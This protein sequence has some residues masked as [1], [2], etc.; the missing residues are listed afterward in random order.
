MVV[1]ALGALFPT[2]FPQEETEPT[3]GVP[4]IRVEVTLAVLH[5]TVED[6]SG[7]AI[8]GLSKENFMVYD[9]GVPQEISVFSDED[10]PVTMGLVI[11]NSGSMANKRE[12]VISAALAFAKSRN[13]R[14]E[15]FVVHF[16]D[17]A[18]FGLPQGTLFASSATELESAFEGFRPR[19]R[20]ALYDAIELA[21]KHLERGSFD[22]K[23]LLVVSDGG[24]NASHITFKEALDLA[25]RSNAIIYTIGVFDEMADDKN[26]GV[27]KRLAK[28]TGGQSY[29]PDS[30]GEITGICSQIATDIRNQ[31]TIGY[32]P[33]QSVA[34]PGYHEVRVTAQDPRHGKLKVRTREGYTS[35]GSASP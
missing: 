20:T 35:P 22:K 33:G 23:V 4:S 30:L 10:V 13:E 9:K 5:A 2:A 29:I 31:Y 21:L 18:G 14:D 24:D 19:G 1:F 3:G 11:D 16:D 12:E 28:A 8:P 25:D 27:V 26:P 34:V 6:R 7:N 32:V 17:Y 15:M